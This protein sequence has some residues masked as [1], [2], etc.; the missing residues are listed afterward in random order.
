MKLLAVTGS[1][2]RGRTID[3]LMD[4]AIEGARAGSGDI[5][6]EKLHLVDKH[7]EY[8]KNCMVCRND[9]PDKAI[10]RC[11]IDDDMQKIYPKMAAAD[12][13][14][15]GTP[16][17]QGTVTAVMKTFLD[18][19]CWVLSKPGKWPVDGCPTPRTNRNKQAIIILSS[20]IISPLLRHWCDDA[21]PLL[22]SFCD[23]MLNARLRGSLY[24]GA[25]EKRGIGR[26]LPKAYFL[27]Q[28]LVR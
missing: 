17:N 19:C 24:A 13:Y 12:A 4:K 21:T 10:A 2:R 5:E 18:R 22:K 9:D 7:I 6:I 20:G 27:G 26:Y 8:C 15:F 23:S 14:I 28:K 11:V 1:Y 3:T 16:I 25:V